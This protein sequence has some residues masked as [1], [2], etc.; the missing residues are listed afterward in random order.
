MTA[1][2]VDYCKLHTLLL[3]IISLSNMYQN[4][5]A[6]LALL[7]QFKCQSGRLN[8]G[9]MWQVKEASRNG[10]ISMNWCET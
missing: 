10:L 1:W 3:E 5:L 9:P 6:T 8:K 7:A 2:L 4:I